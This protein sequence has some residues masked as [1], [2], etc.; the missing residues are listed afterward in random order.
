MFFP[1]GGLNFQTRLRIVHCVCTRVDCPL[2]LRSRC[3]RW[4]QTRNNPTTLQPD[5]STALSP[6]T[7]LPSRIGYLSEE[8]I[9]INYV[10]G[11]I[12]MFSVQNILF[13]I[14]GYIF[15]ALH[16]KRTTNGKTKNN[17]FLFL[18][19]LSRIFR[20]FVNVLISFYSSLYNRGNAFIYL[21]CLHFYYIHSLI[22]FDLT[23]N[24]FFILILHVI[25]I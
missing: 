21:S 20:S 8:M 23:Q 22:L 18:S 10:M 13:M 12:R 17:L 16:Y 7:T 25:N 3:S 15:F 24:S 4:G 11:I 2:L 1:V 14:S 19:G 9:Y 6:R 5:N